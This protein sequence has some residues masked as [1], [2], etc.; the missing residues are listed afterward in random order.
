MPNPPIN[1]TR[2]FIPSSS[3]HIY[4]ESAG[5][6]DT[7]IFCHGLGGNHAN[8]FQQ[9]PVFARTYRTV[10]WDQR[11]FGQSTNHGRECSP[12]LAVTDLKALVDRLQIQQAHLI[13]QSMGGWAAMGFALAYPERVQS[14]VLTDT[15]AGI[16]TAEIQQGFTQLIQQTET[17][18]SNLRLGH[19][20][21]IGVTLS[22]NN[23][24]QAYLYQQLG[25]FGEPPSTV[26]M[27]KILQN[28]SYPNE[29][30]QKLSL[31]IFCLV[32]SE[33]QLIPPPLLRQAA[34]IL[35][36]AH[37]IEIPG[38]GHSPYFEMPDTWNQ[39]VLDFLSAQKR[40]VV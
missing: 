2:G 37:I 27:F 39:L 20:P 29:A 1:I 14:L 16:S 34:A 9:V 36:N 5:Q 33:D 18:P 38:A 31:P 21:A 6:G 4:Y 28:T 19:H 35:P 13:G 17:M 30:L 12:A 11:G 26:E 10:I 24:T 32:G 3:E 7:I 25:S 15:F 23:I 22:Q 40:A 8:W